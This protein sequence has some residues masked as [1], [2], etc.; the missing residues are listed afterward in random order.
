MAMD[1]PPPPE[2][3]GANWLFSVLT[4][5]DAV[6]TGPDLETS[7]PAEAH[8]RLIAA[9]VTPLIADHVRRYAE[10]LRV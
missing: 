9:G 5:A 8:R 1:H 3:V 2:A 4:L 10:N 7:V 6:A